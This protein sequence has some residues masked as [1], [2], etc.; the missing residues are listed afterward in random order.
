MKLSVI[1]IAF[2]L[3][4]VLKT[5]RKTV[6]WGEAISRFVLGGIERVFNFAPENV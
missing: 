6:V 2:V 4:G 1:K 5:G 3:R